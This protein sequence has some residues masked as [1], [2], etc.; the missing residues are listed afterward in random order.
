MSHDPRLF[1]WWHKPFNPVTAASSRIPSGAS[2]PPAPL[3]SPVHPPISP[4]PSAMP[5]KGQFGLTL[6][7]LRLEVHLTVAFAKT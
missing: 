4:L 1:D 3:P 7:A 2:L 5:Q 6:E